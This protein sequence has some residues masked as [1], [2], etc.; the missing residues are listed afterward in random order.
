MGVG[1]GF[2]PLAN[3]EMKRKA[4][5]ELWSEL[6]EHITTTWET[7]KGRKY[8]FT[9]QDLKLLKSLAS[10]LGSIETMALWEC[11]LR[12]SAFWGP[13]TG[14]LVSGMFMERSV[15]LDHP[16]KKK[17]MAECEKKYGFHDQKELW[18]RLTK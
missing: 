15:L 3:G 5:V 9:G 18:D 13:K 14:Y 16:D 8:H 6:L 4:P 17:Y 1:S 2:I 10:W 7:K 11:Y 12:G